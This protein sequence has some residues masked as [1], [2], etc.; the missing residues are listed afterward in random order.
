MSKRLLNKV[1]L[2]TGGASGIGAAHVRLFAEAGA[3][4]LIC[5]VQEELGRSVADDVKRKGGEA[6][7][8]RLDVADENNWKKAVAE[9]VGR[10]GSLTTLVNN[11]GIFIPGGVESETN[12][13]W[14]RVI[15]INQTGV[16]LGMKTAMPE[17]LK[18][19][20][21]AIVNISSIHGIVGS[22]EGIAYHASKGAVRVMSKTAAVE[23]GRRGVRVNTVFPGVIKTPILDCVPEDMMKVLAEAIPMGKTGVPEDIG[24]C[25]LYLC[26]DEAQFV[27]GAEFVVDGGATAH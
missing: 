10:F 1:A 23:Y 13:G 25:S 27:T 18:T 11:A 21:A 20:N 24:Y 4:V 19:G 2:I 5:D 3:K 17:L 7:F 6:A 26:S 15:A 12:E 8:Y 9:A 22:A 16:W 14:N